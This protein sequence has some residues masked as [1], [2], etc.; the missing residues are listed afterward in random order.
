MPG[1]LA[2]LH[3]AAEIRLPDRFNAAD[4]FVDSNV[5]EGR[6]ARTAFHYQGQ[7][8]TYQQVSDL[9]ARTAG[10]LLGMGLLPEQRI[11][12][13]IPDSPEFAALFFGAIKAGIVPVPLHTLVAGDEL[14]YYL[15]DSGA[16]CVFVHPMFFERLRPLLPPSAVVLDDA[17]EQRLVLAKPLLEAAPTH[18]DDMAFWLYTSGSTGRPK[19][20]VHLQRDMVY[21]ADWYAVPVQRLTAEDRI[22]SASKMFFAYGLGN[23]LYC[24]FRVGA[25]SVLVPERPGPERCLEI[26]QQERP[27][28]FFAVP[29]LY[30][31]ILSV[32]DAEKRYD[33]SSLRLAVSAGEA[34][35]AELYRRFRE[36]FGVEILDGIGSTEMLH[37]FIT[38]R[39]GEVR[40]G[41][42]GLL[43]PGYHARIV[44]EN[45]VDVKP[46]EVGNLWISGPSAAAFYWRKAEQTRRT[47]RGEWLVTGD[48]YRQD[49][50]GFYWY[51]GRA[52]DM[53][54]VGAQWVSPMEVEAA[55]ITHPAVQESAVVAASDAQGL[56]F[57]KAFVVLRQGASATEEE[58]S[59]FLRDTLPRFKIP[60]EILFVDELPKTPTGKIQRFK[61]RS[62]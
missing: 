16:K 58:L 2:S 21:S 45:D 55:L 7:A 31:A 19:G 34:L 25:S 48:K 42:S 11:L 40:P 30:A 49:E 4:F 51:C 32:P 5:Q 59:V 22:F 27:T 57:P 24:P 33:L 35:P 39:A 23:S 14:R 37:V 50:D 60:R 43:V 9:V 13:I 28:L 62:T 53:L 15:E 36:R 44:D 47:M 12:L 29:T 6:G 54:K 61:L 20:A 41:S 56:T 26:I 52:D 18:R 1:P 8:F 3:G 10:A 17:W 46:G 38:N